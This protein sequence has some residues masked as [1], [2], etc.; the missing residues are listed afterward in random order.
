MKTRFG[1]FSRPSDQLAPAA[2]GRQ[3]RDSFERHREA[4]PLLSPS[5]LINPMLRASDLAER[6][7]AVCAPALPLVEAVAMLVRAE[8]GWLPVVKE[9]KPIGVLT[10]RNVIA[11]L[12]G[13]KAACLR[14]PAERVMSRG[15]SR[16][17]DD[18]TLDALFD[19]PAV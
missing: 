11:A 3:D 6:G 19:T 10:E 1:V 8:S 14:L 9:D 15:F 16:V 7:V 4:L 12:A 13:S 17:H 18:A 2:S 5:D